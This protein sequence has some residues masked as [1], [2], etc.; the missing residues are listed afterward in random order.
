MH[1]GGSDGVAQIDKFALTKDGS[2]WKISGN[3]SFAVA[4]DVPAGYA[5]LE[6]KVQE[7][8]FG[9]DTNEDRGRQDEL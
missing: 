9:V 4:P 7:F 1:L 6:M 3:E 8:A 2:G 5:S